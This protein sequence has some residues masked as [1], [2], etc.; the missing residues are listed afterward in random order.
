ML[1]SMDAD[2]YHLKVKCIC[3]N[4]VTE[5]REI[6]TLKSLYAVKSVL[7]QQVYTYI[8]IPL[9]IQKLIE[10]RDAVPC[11]MITT[12]TFSIFLNFIRTLPGY[13]R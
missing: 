5:S 8:Y 12:N 3:R 6:T 7:L 11:G 4:Y 10:I 13:E 9:S 1:F 2:W